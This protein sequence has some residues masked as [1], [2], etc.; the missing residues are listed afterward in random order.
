MLFFVV[1]A[2]AFLLALF[3]TPLAIRI[4]PR[5][6]AIDRPAQRRVHDKP[7]PRLGGVPIFV[8]LLIAI[9]VSL[10]YP[11]SDPNESTRLTGLFLGAFVMFAIGLFDDHAELP[12]A[13][14]L[15]AQFVAASI[16]VG[17]GVMIWEL[18]NPFGDV[19]SLE[20]W[21]AVAFTIFWLVGM[22]NTVNWL[23]G[24]DGLATGVVGIAGVIL[25]IHTVR[26][27]QYSIA[28]LALAL[29]GAALGFLPFNF[30][31]AKIF[32]GTAGA[33]VLGF[34]LGVLSIIGG[35]KVAFALLVLSVPILDVA[36]QIFSR[37]RT[38]QSP[39]APTRTHLHHRL[40]DA[41]LSPRAIVL[42]YYLVTATAGGL[43]LFLPNGAYKLF[44]LA[45]IG[46]GALLVL[47]RI[48]Q[49]RTPRR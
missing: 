7:T 15:I 26:L 49:K 1:P 37:V 29:S 25:F 40:L 2:L 17:S 12:A 3:I 31:P 44:A 45:V 10:G 48:T 5:L 13:P 20:S 27:G 38:G 11:R 4:A 33:F 47:A 24:V 41:G 46:F 32:M 36:W 16:A 22:M 6:G 9:F 28:L 34:V 18:P 23:D 19:L 8:A 35:A 14:Q 30:Q 39:F 43:T 42:L 21:M